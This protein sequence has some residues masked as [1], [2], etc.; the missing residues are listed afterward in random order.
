MV[1]TRGVLL[2]PETSPDQRGSSTNILLPSIP[3][4]VPIPLVFYCIN[5]YLVNAYELMGVFIIS[6]IKH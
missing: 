1:F 5:L 6:S 4:S 2:W 3:N